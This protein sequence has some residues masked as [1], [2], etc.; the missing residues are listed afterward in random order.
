MECGAIRWECWCWYFCCCV[1]NDTEGG[2]VFVDKFVDA[3]VDAFVDEFVDAFVDAFVDEF[4]A[5]PLPLLLHDD[6]V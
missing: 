4:D 6:D 2:V 5:L 1:V 3:F